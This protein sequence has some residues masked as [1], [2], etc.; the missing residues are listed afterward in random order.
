MRVIYKKIKIKNVIDFRNK[1]VI[2]VKQ[3]NKSKKQK[4]AQIQNK[5]ER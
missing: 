3:T 2:L 1:T 5:T 4:N